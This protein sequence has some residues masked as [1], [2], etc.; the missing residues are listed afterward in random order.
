MVM[1]DL[2]TLFNLFFPIGGTRQSVFVE[3]PPHIGRGKF[4]NF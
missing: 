3:Y 4:D 2:I 1:S